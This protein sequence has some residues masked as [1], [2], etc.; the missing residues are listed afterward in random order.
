MKKKAKE[1]LVKRLSEQFIYLNFA[2]VIFLIVMPLSYY[3]LFISSQYYK[4]ERYIKE[5]DVS[6]SQVGNYVIEEGYDLRSDVGEVFETKSRICMAEDVQILEKT[7]ASSKKVVVTFTNGCEP[8]VIGLNYVLLHGFTVFYFLIAIVSALVV[9]LANFYNLSGIKIQIKKAFT[10][11]EEQVEEMK[12]IGG[13]EYEKK[14]AAFSE[15]QSLI[16]DIDDLNIQINNYIFE[17][18]T[19]VS[20]LNHE[21]KSP[22]NKMNS[23][24]QAHQMEIPGYENSDQ[25]IGELEHE[26]DVLLNIVNFTLDIFVKSN[27][28]EISKVDITKSIEKILKRSHDK[29]KLNNLTYK[30]TKS[31]NLIIDSD[32]RLV[33]LILSNLIENICKYAE[34]S[35]E[36]TIDISEDQVIIENKVS[37]IRKVGTQQG[38]KLSTQLVRTVGYDLTYSEENNI[39]KVILA[40]T[41]E[42]KAKEL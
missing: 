30:L 32:A 4:L 2:I 26:L 39:F 15:F 11:I 35:S 18:H 9:I 37:N 27:L 19:L 12:I 1:S 42:A 16:N 31:A 23:L 38:L 28:K 34:K 20:T 33:D 41:P 25:I 22:I 21:L 3:Q 13:P 6:A 14:E 8:M 40:Q 36:F 17:R 5:N 7:N 29:L 10:K 24:I